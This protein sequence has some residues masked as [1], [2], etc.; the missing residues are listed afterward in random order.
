[1][2]YLMSIVYVIFYTPASFQFPLLH[3]FQ[4]GPEHTPQMH[5]SQEAYRATPPFF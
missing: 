3:L 4:L 2:L 1:M 5:C